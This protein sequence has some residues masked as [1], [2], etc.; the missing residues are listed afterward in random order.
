MAYAVWQ[1]TITDAAGKVLAGVTIEVKRE[2]VG[3]PLATIYEDRDGTT[4]L[5]NPFSVDVEGF[6]RFYISGGAYQIRAYKSGFERLWRHVAIGLLGEADTAEFLERT[7]TT[8]GDIAIQD[9]DQIVKLAPTS[10]ATRNC[11]LPP[12]AVK[13]GP[14]TIIDAS[15]VWD[16][17]ATTFS[18]DGGGLITDQSSIVGS[19]KYGWYNFVPYGTGYL[20]R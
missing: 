17:F 15:G 1:A 11:V 10:P 12:G 14:V 6:A 16:S 20:L 8:S 18:V 4:P 19:A 5:G 13:R 7:E 9:F 2:I 3:Q